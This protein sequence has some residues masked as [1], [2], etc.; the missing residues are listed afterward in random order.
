MI[1]DDNNVYKRVDAKVYIKRCIITHY[2]KKE[3]FAAVVIWT[4]M[5]L[6]GW[7]LLNF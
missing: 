3:Y 4:E 5:E 7:R 1:S 2:E 6:L